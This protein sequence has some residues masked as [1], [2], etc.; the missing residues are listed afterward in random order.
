MES[1]KTNNFSDFYGNNEKV[2]NNVKNVFGSS[3]SAGDLGYEIYATARQRVVQAFEHNNVKRDGWSSFKP[4]PTTSVSLDPPFKEQG[5]VNLE[6]LKVFST[7]KLSNYLDNPK[8]IGLIVEIYA[9]LIAIAEA[10]IRQKKEHNM[11]FTD[12][13]NYLQPLWDDNK[14][15]NINNIF[16][17]KNG[18]FLKI[19]NNDLKNIISIGMKPF[20]NKYKDEKKMFGKG[21][22]Y[23]RMINYKGKG[24]EDQY[25]L[26][27]EVKY[28]IIFLVYQIKHL[29]TC[30]NTTFQGGKRTLKNKPKKSRRKQTRRK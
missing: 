11:L 20:V 26:N 24:A 13:L 5:M 10:G 7:N 29:T 17:E 4:Y 9:I 2:S 19:H 6:Q 18:D 16:M 27:L 25:K 30:M 23:Q 21:G 15:S 28:T 8:I 1:E 14:N 22:F 3:G 12:I